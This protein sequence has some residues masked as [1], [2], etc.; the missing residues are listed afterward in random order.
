M[1]FNKVQIYPK[2]CEVNFSFLACNL[3]LASKSKSL[4]RV[5]CRQNKLYSGTWYKY[6]GLDWTGLVFFLTEYNFCKFFKIQSIKYLRQYFWQHLVKF[7]VYLIT[8]RDEQKN[9]DLIYTMTFKANTFTWIQ[10][11]VCLKLIK[12]LKIF[13]VRFKVNSELFWY[14]DSG[15]NFPHQRYPRANP[16]VAQTNFMNFIKF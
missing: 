12:S 9:E 7:H 16:L 5:T 2:S 15:F 11:R 6:N 13:L 3:D 14:P 10:F 4:K 8:K 1:S